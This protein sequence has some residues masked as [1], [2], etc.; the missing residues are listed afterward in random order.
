MG[1]T[2]LF[3]Y[4]MADEVAGRTVSGERIQRLERSHVHAELSEWKQ[5]GRSEAG[6]AWQGRLPAPALGLERSIP[7]EVKVEHEGRDLAYNPRLR[8]NGGPDEYFYSGD[9]IFIVLDAEAL[10]PGP[11][12]PVTVDYFSHFEPEGP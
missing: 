4:R 2:A 11:E 1:R 12:R 7:L 9:Q 10:A 5:L 8:E 6:T 3:F